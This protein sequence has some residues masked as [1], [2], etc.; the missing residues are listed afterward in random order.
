[1][2]R[3]DPSRIR[4]SRASVRPTIVTRKPGADP[5]IAR[6]SASPGYSGTDTVQRKDG[7]PENTFK[8]GQIF[9]NQPAPLVVNGKTEQNTEEGKYEGIGWENNRPIYTER[10]QVT[11]GFFRA[12]SEYE[13][14]SKAGLNKIKEHE[15][16]GAT[17]AVPGGVFDN[18][19]KTGIKMIGYG[20]VLTAAE[21]A[22][23]YE[24]KISGTPDW[25]DNP[26]VIQATVNWKTSVLTEDQ[27]TILLQN[28]LE[29]VY[30]KIKSSLGGARITQDQFDALVNFVFN[31]GGDAF[32]KSGI[33]GMISGGKYDA[34]PTEMV[35]WILACGVEK[36]EL[37]ARRIDNACLFSGTLR[38][39][40]FAG[41][42]PET[43]SA[44]TTGE[45]AMQ[46]MAWFR[47]AAGGGFSCNQAAG[48]VANLITESGDLN[49]AARNPR[50]GALGLAQ[51]LGND[52]A[53]R[54][55]RTYGPFPAPG[56]AFDPQSFNNQLDFVT[57]EL[58][59]PVWPDGRE[60]AEFRRA[61]I[62]YRR[63]GAGPNEPIRL[64]SA[65]EYAE[66]FRVTYERNN[67][68]PGGRYAS[69]VAANARELSEK[70][71]GGS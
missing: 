18:T 47:S 7:A 2:A 24:I 28:D 8:T 61:G 33:A 16:T 71:C 1:M 62:P 42:A 22:E 35:K 64:L 14:V 36:S 32:D 51:W 54:Y 5:Y 27:A 37:K 25:E 43:A 23:P 38:A 31:V 15:G 29:P 63:G 65:A 4:P 9:A 19:C 48:I 26:R 66:L 70:Y 11:E 3:P 13:K 39:G 49:P 45:R 55:I 68:P 12:V 10:K 58:T 20:H 50:S 53:G 57:K 67:E 17:T 69:K 6:N 56:S 44:A 34:V 30:S 46:A 40:T 41:A 59:V 21:L 60:N 52:R